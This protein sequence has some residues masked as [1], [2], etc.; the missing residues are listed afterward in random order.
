INLGAPWDFDVPSAN[1]PATILTTTTNFAGHC[2]NTFDATRTWQ[3]SD[4]C[5]N[6]AT[7]SQT[8]TVVDTVAPIINCAG[9]ASKTVQIGMPWAFD[10]P[11]ATDNSGQ[12]A[13]V[14]LSTVTNSV[15]HCGNTFD[16]TRV[17]QAVDGCSN[18]AT[19]SQTV[20]V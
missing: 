12:V 16:A 13:I 2:G 14:V 10:A 11:T 1:Y 7:C 8:V 5:G 18:S 3:V 6:S 9:S 20:M 19:C 17:W 4:T 15:G